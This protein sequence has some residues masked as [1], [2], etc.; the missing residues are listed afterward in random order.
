M[1]HLIG[2]L[3]SSHFNVGGESGAKYP[4]NTC[5]GSFGRHSPDHTVPKGMGMGTHFV[6]GS[7]NLKGMSETK[8]RFNG[9]AGAVASMAD[10]AANKSKMNGDSVHIGGTNA[11]FTNMTTSGSFFYNKDA[12]N[13]HLNTNEQYKFMPNVNALKSH[14]P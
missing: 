10:R 1:N 6:L 4:S 9:P 8:S 3:K 7:D 11:R 14:Y 12:S 5:Y 13:R 2:D